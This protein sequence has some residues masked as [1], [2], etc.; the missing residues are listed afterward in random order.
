MQEI[1]PKLISFLGLWVMLGLAWA[2]SEKGAIGKS[3]E[4]SCTANRNG[5]AV[6]VRLRIADPEDNSRAHGL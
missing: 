5:D 1:T 3:Q 4:R 6:S 2:L